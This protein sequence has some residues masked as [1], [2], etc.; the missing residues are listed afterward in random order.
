M[1][2]P[3]ISKR[4]D[5][6]LAIFG[7]CVLLAFQTILIA[8]VIPLVLDSASVWEFVALGTAIAVIPITILALSSLKSQLKNLDSRKEDC[9]HRP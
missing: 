6:R 1:G 5:L 8:H 4:A 9:G 7:L 3:L 2:R